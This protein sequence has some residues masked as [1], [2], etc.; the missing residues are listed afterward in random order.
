[1]KPVEYSF[2]EVDIDIDTKGEALYT[3][4]CSIDS[5]YQSISIVNHTYSILYLPV[6]NQAKLGIIMS[7][8]YLYVTYITHSGS[9]S[10]ANKSID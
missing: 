8:M 7:V 5:R 4:T 2:F 10:D 3:T 9:G 1:M 6:Q